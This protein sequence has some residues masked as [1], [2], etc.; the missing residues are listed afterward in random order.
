MIF[1]TSQRTLLWL[2]SWQMRFPALENLSFF[3]GL[4][5]EDLALLAPCLRTQRLR[6][7]ALIFDQGEAAEFFYLLVRGEVVIRYK[8]EDGPALTVTRVRPGEVFGWSAAMGN[9][10]YTSAAVC[11]RDS[12]VLQIRGDALRSLCLGNPRAGELIR[13]RLA[14]VVAEREKSR[15]RVVKMLNADASTQRAQGGRYA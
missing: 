14:A 12:E 1:A 2:I 5:E 10:T 11:E 7:G 9:E 8:P 3:Q 4:S 6:A 15:Q 13:A